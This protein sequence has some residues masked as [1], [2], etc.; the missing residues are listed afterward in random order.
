MVCL[1][2]AQRQGR[3]WCVWPRRS[4]RGVCGV[5]GPPQ[6]QGRVWC[7]L[8][9]AQRQGRACRQCLA[10]AQRQGRVSHILF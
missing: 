5:F 2:P 6:R 7:V 4:G 8:A 3:V 10:P 9:P 1:A